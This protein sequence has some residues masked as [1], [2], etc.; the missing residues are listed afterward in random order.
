MG[1]IWVTSH[2]INENWNLEKKLLSFRELD[3]P[4]TRAQ[5]FNAILD[6]FREY[7]VID[8]IF[9]ITLDNAFANDVSVNSFLCNV[10]LA[11]GSQFFHIR[12]FYHIINLIAKDG[13]E[14][15][16]GSLSKIREVI[17]ILKSPSKYQEFYK[18]TLPLYGLKKKKF[19]LN[20][21]IRWSSTYLMLAF[22]EDYINAFTNVN[23]KLGEGSTIAYDWN[24]T[25]QYLNFLKVFYDAV[26]RCHSCMFNNL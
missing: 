14:F 11:C 25:F 26:L 7:N 4:H 23:Y 3:Y 15:M 16:S 6:I 2:F 12:Y 22:Y 9:N 13:L 21:K 20:I 24:I 18:N 1:Y 5:I 8:K 10:T 19:K 17:R